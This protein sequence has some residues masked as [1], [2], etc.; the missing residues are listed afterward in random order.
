VTTKTIALVQTQAETGGAQ[1]VAR[2]LA[3]GFEQRGYRV[4]QIFFYRRS[5]SFDADPNSFFCASARPSSP[6]A[7]AR[8]LAALF[9]E[10]RRTRP[11]AAITLQHYG[12]VIGAPVARLAGAPLILANQLS[13]QAVIPAPARAIDRLLGSLGLYDAI[14][15]NSAETERDYRRW[16]ASYRRRL[17]R[18]DHGFLDKTSPASKTEARAALGL[19][20]EALLLGCAARLAPSKQLELAVALLLFDRRWRL[21]LAGVG[22][23]RPRLEQQARAQGVDERLHFLGELDT[24]QMG[25][26]LAAL[27]CFVFPSAAESFGLAPVEAAQAGVPVVAN[28]VEVLR[29]VLQVD[30][31][32]CALFVDAAD[33]AAFA[34]A[35][36]RVLNDTA[37]AAALTTTGR[38][39]AARYPLDAMVEGY[40]RLIEQ[41]AP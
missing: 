32:P 25:L 37:V 6:L 38:R 35:V 22:P 41:A 4:R 19:P 5:A 23:A 30:G 26:F 14:V 3:Q 31:A 17:T 20:R 13:A 9:H 1:E 24:T 18:I 40:V 34:D 10:L 27:D 12:N 15:V 8:M 33:A 36:R 7:L 2:Q 11:A 28:D 21:V 39:L 29:D 16:P